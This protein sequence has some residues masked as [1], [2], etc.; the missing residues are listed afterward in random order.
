MKIFLHF[1]SEVMAK[2]ME[3]VLTLL[4]DIEIVSAPPLATAVITDSVSLARQASHRGVAKIIVI[5]AKPTAD[6]DQVVFMDSPN[7]VEILN[8]LA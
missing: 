1:E 5:G 4:K 6:L 2:A 3:Q 7:L 8:A